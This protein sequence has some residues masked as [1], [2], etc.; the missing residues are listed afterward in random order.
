MLSGVSEGSILGPPLFIFLIDLFLIV[1]DV[2]IVNHVDESKTY[3]SCNT[4]EE[5]I[6]KFIHETFSVPF[7]LSDE[8]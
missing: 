7:R 8:V 6:T 2:D 1:K 3:E 4:I 5:V